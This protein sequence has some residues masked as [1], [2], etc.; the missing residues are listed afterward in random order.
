LIDCM[1]TKV[2]GLIYRKRLRMATLLALPT[3]LLLFRWPW[4]TSVVLHLLEPFYKVT[5]VQSCNI[6][7]D[8]NWYS[9]SQVR[10]LRDGYSFYCK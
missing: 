2:V 6:W 9:S 5:F 8:L 7:Q 3:K 1:P 4:M 10:F